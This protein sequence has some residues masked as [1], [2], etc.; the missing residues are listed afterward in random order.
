M[1]PQ[2]NDKY[3]LRNYVYKIDNFIDQPTCKQLIKKISKLEWKSHG[4][5][6][7]KNNT[8]RTYDNEL[9]VLQT[10]IPEV[11][12]LN[13]KIKYAI[14]EY[15]SKFTTLFWSYNAY[16]YIRLNRYNK[17][18]YMRTH[19]DHIYSL[20]DGTKKGVPVLSILGAL[21]SNYTGGDFIMFEQ[22]V[23]KLDP[24]NLLIFPSSF[25]FP[26]EVTPVLSGTRYTYISWCW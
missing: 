23:I 17:N 13:S 14:E 15:I 24:G 10:D 4:Y 7:E 12:Q 21:N 22:D 2:H 20:F 26:H 16:S 9:S 6:D 18:T 11:K 3:D 19:C 8:V 5:W 25:L 1:I